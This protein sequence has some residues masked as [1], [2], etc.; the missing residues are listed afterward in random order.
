M[1]FY[2][3]LCFIIENMDTNTAGPY[4]THKKQAKLLDG[5]RTKHHMGISQ[6]VTNPVCSLLM[7]CSYRILTKVLRN[8]ENVS[9]ILSAE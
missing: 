7:I 2:R 1:C 6:Q 9:F 8:T 5:W 4:L 3:E